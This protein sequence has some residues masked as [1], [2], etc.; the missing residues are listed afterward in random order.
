[1]ISIQRKKQYYGKAENQNQE[2]KA[3][4][5]KNNVFPKRSL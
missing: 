2:L 5:R 1:M 4:T 3:A